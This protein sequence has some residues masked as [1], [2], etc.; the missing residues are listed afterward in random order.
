[1]NAFRFLEIRSSS[2]SLAPPSFPYLSLGFPVLS[3][4]PSVSGERGNEDSARAAP[5]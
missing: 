4:K 2:L 3:R 5:A 1:M